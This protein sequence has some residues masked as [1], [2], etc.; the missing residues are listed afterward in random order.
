MK[1]F[2]LAAGKGTRLGKLTETL[3]KALVD[4]NGK[5]MLQLLLEKLKNQGFNDVLINIHHHGDKIVD[6]LKEN[7]NF[8]LDVK[9]SDERDELLDTGGAVKKA[10]W[11]F[12]GNEPVLVHNVD[13]Y[14][15]L[16]FPDLIKTH[17]QSRNL[18]TL[19]VKER[20]SSRKLLF[21]EELRLAGWKNIKSG[22]YKWV[23]A[24][25][26]EYVERAY[27]GIYIASPG[28]PGKIKNT[29]SFPVVPVW[30]DL[31]KNNSVKG[32]EHNNSLWFDLGTVEKISVAEKILSKTKSRT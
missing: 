28:Y 16:Y 29:G 10:A 30:L 9:I 31:A 4:F 32:L 5:P 13:I 14:T 23:N 26:K 8:G 11:F 19:L 12:E 6:F 25:L 3:P 21:D 7:K 20:E 15:D 2:I 24:P 27:S 22:E 17:K 1:A 18:V